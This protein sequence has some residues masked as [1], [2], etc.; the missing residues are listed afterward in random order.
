[1]QEQCKWR[2]ET[3]YETFQ[4]QKIGLGDCW[5]V[6]KERDEPCVA[7][8]LGDWIDDSGIRSANIY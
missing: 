6:G 8:G 4:E 3:K 2:G 5:I 1:M 7:S